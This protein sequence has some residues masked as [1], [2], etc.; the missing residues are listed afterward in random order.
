MTVDEPPRRSLLVTA[1]SRHGATQQ[2][3]DRICRQLSFRLPPSAWDIHFTDIDDVESLEDYDAAVIGSAI[4]FGR[5]LKRATRLLDDASASP[6]MG[7]WLFSSG[8]VEFDSPPISAAELE[9]DVRERLDIKDSVVFAGRMTGETRHAGR[10]RRLQAVGRHRRLG[11]W[12]RRRP[13]PVQASR[14]VDDPIRPSSP[15]SAYV[16]PASATNTEQ[17]KS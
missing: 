2:I 9:P 10:R 13:G 14:T 1:A 4:Y 11:R 8:P 3:A 15:R 5:W 7:L 17:E 16:N 12:H 6:G